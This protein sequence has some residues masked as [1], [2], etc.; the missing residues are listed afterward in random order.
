MATPRK[1]DPQK[2]GRKPKYKATYPEL[3]IEHMRKG[4][5]FKSFGAVI[6][7][8]CSEQTL[9]TWVKKYPAFLEARKQGLLLLEKWAIDASRQMATGQV[10][11]VVRSEPVL[12]ANGKPVMDPNPKRKGQVL[13]KEWREP[14][15]I[16]PAVHIFMLKN[17][18]KWTDRQDLKV[19]GDP[20]APVEHNHRHRVMTQEERL[21]EIERLRRI[22]G[23]CGND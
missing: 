11:V 23:Q 6:N 14:A 16:Y 3:L 13:M 18:L 1:A 19:S 4:Y 17:V 20:E 2:A 8:T 22:R 21:A 10:T 12:D 9:H 15:K 5:N 7:P